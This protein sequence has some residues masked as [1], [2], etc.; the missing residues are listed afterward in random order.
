[1]R[2]SA[3][4]VLSGQLI[5]AVFSLSSCSRGSVGRSGAESDA[6]APS[7]HQPNLDVPAGYSAE[8]TES[9]LRQ[10]QLNSDRR[11]LERFERLFQAEPVAAG[12]A[13]LAGELKG[14]IMNRYGSSIANLQSSCRSNVC[15]LEVSLG[16]PGVEEEKRVINPIGQQL[17]EWAPFMS[18]SEYVRI[19]TV[20]AKGRFYLWRSGRPGL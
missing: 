7:V 15:K 16:V 13:A 8:L 14:A 12:D 20:D 18:F 3:A 19:G 2:G 5:C 9:E 11:R 17:G 1:M 6:A 10:A 4:V